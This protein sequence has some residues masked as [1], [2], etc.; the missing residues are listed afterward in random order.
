MDL[1]SL[2][3]EERHNKT[4]VDVELKLEVR[5]AINNKSAIAQ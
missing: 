4:D 5:Q 2:R 1:K 3:R